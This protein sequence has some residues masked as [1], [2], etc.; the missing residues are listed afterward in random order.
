[1]NS[2]KV[3]AAL[4]EAEKRLEEARAALARV[5]AEDGAVVASPDGPYAQSIELLARAAEAT[6]LQQL[7]REAAKTPTP[8]PSPDSSEEKLRERIERERAQGRDVER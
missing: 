7:Y 5:E 4:D 1:M 3:K 8:A 6:D 2:A